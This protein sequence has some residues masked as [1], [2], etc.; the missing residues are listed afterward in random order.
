MHLERL[1]FD[2]FRNLTD[3]ISLAHP[4]SILVGPNNVGK[5]NVIDALRMVLTPLSGWP[6]R[7]RL[8]DFNHAGTG[9]AAVEEFTITTRFEGLDLPQSG[10]MLTALDGSRDRASLHLQATLPTAGQPRG[11][12]LGGDSRSPDVEEWARTAV[13]YTYLPPLRDAEADMRPGRNNRLVELIAA[14]AGDG[15]DRERVV[16]IAAEANSNLAEVDALAISASRIRERL[17]AISGPRNSQSV[18]LLFSDPVFENVLAT[19]GVGIGDDEPLSMA[20]NGLGMNN[21]L[22]MAVLLAGLTYDHGSELHLLLVEEPEAHLHPQMQDLLMRFLQREVA[23]RDDVQVVVTTHSPNITASAKVEQITALAKHESVIV[24]G[25]IGDFNLE[26]DELDHLGRFLDVTKAALLFADA[27]ILVEGLAEQL[28]LPL[29]AAELSP[30]VDLAECNVTVVNVGGLA[31]GPFAALFDDDRLPG[32]CSILSDGD[33]PASDDD[34][35]ETPDASPEPRQPGEAEAVAGE[36]D[37]VLSATA[38]KLKANENQRR[39]VFLA[40]QTF[41]HDLVL[42]GN[43][44][45]ALRALALLKP[46]VAKRLRS[47]E[48]LDSGEARADAML[49]AVSGVKGRFAQALTRTATQVKADGH[50]IIVPDYIDAAIAWASAGPGDPGRALSE[51]RSEAEGDSRDAG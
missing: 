30:P 8:D 28:V 10:R 20:Q 6:L 48:S 31:F 17:T 23:E 4:V 1:E 51:G 45:W 33:P 15:P 32:R 35:T 25:L 29:L 44:E 16:G 50:E 27:V 37:P 7:P 26:K 40:Q 14:L 13:T 39:H 11:R 46:R 47:D 38:Q 12:F 42:A 21:L 43:W 2:G 49:K 18:E 3:P 24:G 19:L 22:Y 36:A 9:E 41:E 5:S 34:E